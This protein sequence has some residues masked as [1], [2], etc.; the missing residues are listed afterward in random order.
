[1][2]PI[3][4]LMYLCCHRI[5]A[6][7]EKDL[8]HLAEQCQWHRH[9][10]TCW[11]YWKGPLNPRECR[12]D[13]DESNFCSESHVDPETEEICLRCLDGLVNNFNSA[14]FSGVSAKAMMYYI[15]DYITKA[16]LKVHIVYAALERATKK[17][18]EY[19]P[20]VDDITMRVKSLLQKCVYS[21]LSH[22]E[23][24][25]QQVCSHLMDFPD[26]YTSH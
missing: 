15:T 17:L 10:A 3:C 6:L 16:Q 20:D 5:H 22:Q 7:F 2:I 9:S 8:F 1:M 24:S 26:R 19:N 21:M 11:K 23:L 25:V 12:F 14:M 13:L 4:L 18:G